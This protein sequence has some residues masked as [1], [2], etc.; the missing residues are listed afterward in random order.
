MLGRVASRSTFS[1]IVGRCVCSLLE[2][3]VAPAV[4]LSLL[5]LL[6]FPLCVEQFYSRVSFIIRTPV[7]GCKCM[8]LHVRGCAG[9]QAVNRITYRS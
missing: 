3:S 5:L 8:Q 9:P 7:S 4:R 6:F 1:I 2:S